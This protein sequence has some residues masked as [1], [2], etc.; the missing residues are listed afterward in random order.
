[1]KNQYIFKYK[2]RIYS[3]SDT[4]VTKITNFSFF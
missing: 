4:Y 1:M 3:T 2:S